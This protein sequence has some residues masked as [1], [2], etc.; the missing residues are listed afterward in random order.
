MIEHFYVGIVPDD[1]I[2]A[3]PSDVA[4]ILDIDEYGVSSIS[5]LTRPKADVNRSALAG[6]NASR[7]SSAQ[8][9]ERNIVLDVDPRG[10][11]VEATRQALY[12]VLPFDTMLRVYIVTERRT[13]FIDG[14]VET[15]EGDDVAGSIFGMQLSI[16]CP[17]PWFQSVR[18]HSMALVVGENMLPYDG[19][20]SAGFTLTVPAQKSPPLVG[21]VGDLSLTIGGKTFA[22]EGGVSIPTIC[23]I[24][25]SKAFNGVRN[26]IGNTRAP[27]FDALKNDSEWVTISR[28]N[29]TMAVSCSDATKS[30]FEQQ[31]VLTWRDTYSGV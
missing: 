21:S 24:P 26:T 14:Y 13:V 19:D 10:D 27:A 30:F 4:D 31:N 18:L 8:I 25:G 22:Y 17:F 11:D 23:T 5:G 3:I 6:A 9:S 15:L 28:E 1:E 7:I 20:I 29:N 12:S 16:L 2:T